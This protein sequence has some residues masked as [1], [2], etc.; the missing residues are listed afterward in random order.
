MD[1]DVAII[2]GGPAGSTVSTL[3]K[4]YSPSLKVLVLER[5]EF[6]RD[7]I[8]ESLLPPVSQVLE[9]MG[10]F[11]KVDAAQ[12]PIKIGAIYRWG[13]QPELWD[14]N[15]VPPE[16]WVDEPRPAKFAGLRLH[17]AFQVDRSLYDKILLDHSQSLGTEVRQPAKVVKVLKVGDRVSGL[18][19][20]TGETVTARYY[21]DAS[22]NSGIL[23]R[24][25]DVPCDYPSN[26]KN[27]AIYDYWQNAD[28]ASKVGVGATRILVLTVGFGWMW[29]IPI[30]PTRTS[31]GLVVPVEYY[32]QSGKTPEE[33]YKVAIA[34]EPRVQEL[35]TNAESEGKL[36]TTKDWSFFADRQCGENWF[37][38]GECAGFADPILSAGVSMAHIGA[39]QLACT[40]LELFNGKLDALWLKSEY[41]RR[42]KLRI[43]THIRF[44]DYWY[45]ANSQLKELKE[46]TAELARDAGLDLTPQKAWEWIALGG[47]INEDLAVGTGGFSLPLV[48]RSGEYLM[49]IDPGKPLE[50]N[51]IFKLNLEGAESKPMAVYGK[52]V[53]LQAECLVRGDRVLP[54]IGINRS[55]TNIL[56]DESDIT[57]IFQL[58]YAIKQ[59][60][61]NDPQVDA[62]FHRGKDHLEGMVR[63]G[64]VDASYNPSLGLLRFQESEGVLT[65]NTDQP[66]S[67]SNI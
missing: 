9:E 45:M 23:R 19:L 37:L 34:S 11:E 33:L 51:N 60:S 26:L 46:F 22:G 2:G 44:G 49:E 13:R 5:E 12:F 28:W 27:I 18:S 16:V 65:W 42:Q 55:L 52:G 8:G 40:I 36:T 21:V 6:P 67:S 10:C 64:W 38:V 61:P 39:R 59:Q 66:K 63:D 20:S 3:L 54:L 35:L 7:H 29:F 50:T 47:F 17:T 56:R 14:L 25:M 58:I 43:Q 48:R 31:L 32:K 57:R 62:L 24:T 4:K 1:Y 53:I 30:S 15:F 41:E